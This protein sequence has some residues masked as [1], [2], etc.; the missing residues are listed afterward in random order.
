M[1][2]SSGDEVSD[3]ETTVEFV[4][5]DK[6]HHEDKDDEDGVTFTSAIVPGY[7]AYV[8]VEASE[9]G[10]IDA[11]VDFNRDFDWDDAGEQIFVSEPVVQGINYLT[12]DVP[13]NAKTQ[14]TYARFR[15]SSTGGLAPTGYANDGE[16]EDYK[17]E[18]VQE[19]YCGDGEINQVWEQC[20]EGGKSIFDS[21]HQGKRPVMINANGMDKKNAET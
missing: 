14:S 1:T 5:A 10:Y 20:D 12:F 9:A 15:L 4:E 3:E 13:E 8:E 19:G 11:W 18:I 2:P 6:H 17:I 7:W 16:V 21:T